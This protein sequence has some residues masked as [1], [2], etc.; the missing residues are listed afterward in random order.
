MQPIVI[1]SEV[2]PGLNVSTDEQILSLIR[3]S[4][5]TPYHAAATNVMG[6][7]NDPMAVIDSSARV[8]G[9]QGLRVVDASSFPILPP[10]HPQ[11]TVCKWMIRLSTL[12]TAQL[13]FVC[14]RFG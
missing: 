7:L 9:V 13:T 1:G 2:F 6:S 4:A 5:L 8:I 3:Q 14:R 11:A 10:G 12:W